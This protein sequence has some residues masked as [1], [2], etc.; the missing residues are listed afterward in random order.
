VNGA[1]KGVKGEN[2]RNDSGHPAGFAKR[3]LRLGIAYIENCRLV[4]EN[5]LVVYRSKILASKFLITH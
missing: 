4:R 2:Q 3:E 1:A 5:G